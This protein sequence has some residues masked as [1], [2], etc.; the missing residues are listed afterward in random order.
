MKNSAKAL[1][2][3]ALLLLAAGSLP[4]AVAPFVT[5]E[6][7]AISLVPE[8][9]TPPGILYQWTAEREAL[10]QS[11]EAL[12][13]EELLGQV[14]RDLWPDLRT[15][16]V[17]ELSR[18]QLEATEGWVLPEEPGDLVVEAVGRDLETGAVHVEVRGP[19][20]PAKYGI[21]FRFLYLYGVVDSST[22]TLD[23]LVVTIRGWVE[24]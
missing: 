23:R 17:L 15:L 11:P 7:V 6:G 16:D 1:P 20:L 18:Y 3:A 22:G 21:V 13:A 10:R 5:P 8:M 24:E 19:R 12:E 14:T 4:G 2:L 9:E